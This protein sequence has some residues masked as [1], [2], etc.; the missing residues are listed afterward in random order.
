MKLSV[1]T[2]A[3][4]YAAGRNYAS[5]VIGFCTSLGLISVA[6]SK[7]LTESLGQIYDGVAL[8]TQGF[9]SIWQVLVVVGGPFVGAIL[10]WY[11]QR[12]A[13]TPNVVQQVVATAQDPTDPKK[14]EAA[15]VVLANAAVQA[16]AEKVVAPG[17]ADN[18]ATLP[19]VVSK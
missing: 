13:K 9:T 8:I 1:E 14:A 3:R 2:L 11:A 17:I 10:A 15:K 6:Q 19:N 4:I 18:P 5:L 7:T 12:S 16:G